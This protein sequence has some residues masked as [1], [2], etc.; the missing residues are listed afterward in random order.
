MI[1]ASIKICHCDSSFRLC[2]MYI[3]LPVLHVYSF[4][5]TVV[6][7]LLT[8]TS[9]CMSFMVLFRINSHFN[10][11]LSLYIHVCVIFYG[12]YLQYINILCV[13]MYYKCM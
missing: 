1:I 10:L 5:C 2:L 9:T 8:C 13:L 3:C 6:E 11:L 12:H 4:L 7:L